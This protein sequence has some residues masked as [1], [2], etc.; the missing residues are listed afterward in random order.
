MLV[1]VSSS[2]RAT[3]RLAALARVCVLLAWAVPAAAQGLVEDVLVHG[4][5]TTPTD[6]VLALAGLSAGQPMAA[7]RLADVERRLRESGRFADVSVQVRQRSLDPAG[8]VMVVIVVTERAGVSDRVLSPG[9]ARRLRAALMLGPILQYDD[10]YGATYGLRPALVDRPWRNLNISA[11]LTW[12]GERRAAVEAAQTLTGP[13][14]GQLRA[15]GGIDRRVNPFYD[16]ADTRRSGWVRADLSLTSWWRVSGDVRRSLV[17]F[18]DTDAR[19][20]S[21][22][23]ATVV[24][25]R[26]DDYA[27]ALGMRAGAGV[28]W[29]QLDGRWAPPLRRTNADVAVSLPLIRWVTVRP[30]APPADGDEDG[31]AGGGSGSGAGRSVVLA[32]RARTTRA[33]APL[34]A[35][36]QALLGGALNL[37]GVRPGAAVGDNATAV[38]AELRFAGGLTPLARAGL[39]AFLDGAA[40][41]PAGVRLRDEALTWGAGGGLFLQLGGRTASLDV[42]WPLGGGRPRLHV[43]FG[44]GLGR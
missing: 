26:A 36:E 40:V 22:G 18:A 21:G 43:Q 14:R 35:W 41:S 5:H 39:R 31:D 12:G 4:N 20:W 11:P 13:V 28:D 17:R 24:D 15:G 10:G 16:V 1:P 42:G 32:L 7:T 25:P 30:T 2:K 27:T 9:L 8:P 37:R 23:V 38:S 3:R 44:G 19:Q 29:L 6:Q 34:P 33:S